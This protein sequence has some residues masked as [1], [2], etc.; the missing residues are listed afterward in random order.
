M[1]FAYWMVLVAAFLPGLTMGTAK[2]AAGRKYDN[3]APR[4]WAEK[5]SG[6]QRRAGWAQNNHFEA[7]PGF[8]AGVIIAELCHVPQPRID[9]LA[10]IFIA[11]R[12]VYTGVY[13]AGYASLRTLVWL[14]GAGAVV[15]LFVSGI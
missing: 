8:A 1:N 5:L 12:L 4:A 9:L 3:A 10:G 2:A 13:L 11:A 7:F 15:M 6:W 14:V